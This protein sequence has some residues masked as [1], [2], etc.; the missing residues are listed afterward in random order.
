VGFIEQLRYVV[1]DSDRHD[2]RPNV[3][4]CRE[5]PKG[6]LY[7]QMHS[8][9]IDIRTNSFKGPD[10]AKRRENIAR[11]VLNI[12]AYIRLDDEF[13]TS[14]PLELR[15]PFLDILY[16]TFKMIAENSE[17]GLLCKVLANHAHNIPECFIKKRNGAPMSTFSLIYYWEC[18]RPCILYGLH[19][20]NSEKKD[21]GPKMYEKLFEK[22]WSV[23]EQHLP[24]NRKVKIEFKDEDASKRLDMDWST[25]IN[26]LKIEYQM[27]FMLHGLGLF[28]DTDASK[29]AEKD[30][31]HFKQET[32]DEGDDGHVEKPGDEGSVC[33]KQETDDGEDEK[34][35]L[36]S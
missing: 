10:F 12:P 25:G 3:W 29:K 33:F 16:K 2:V 14:C 34:A 9:L 26:P 30:D 6:G 11:D 13:K 7:R 36:S 1:N 21:Y 20:G 8:A 24:L 31:I 32:D 18:Q 27:L 17:D 15:T 28:E 5:P 23:I 19:G 35:M 4:Q 22:E